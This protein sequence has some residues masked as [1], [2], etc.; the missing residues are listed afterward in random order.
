ME[1]TLTQFNITFVY[2]PFPNFILKIS[3]RH[4]AIKTFVG[5]H[6]SFFHNYVIKYIFFDY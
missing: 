6:L 1:T 4:V 5:Y 2:V 3:T